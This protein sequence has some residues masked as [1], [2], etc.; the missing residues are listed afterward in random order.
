MDRHPVPRFKLNT[1][2]RLCELNQIQMN[3]FVATTWANET[4]V[5]E[6]ISFTDDINQAGA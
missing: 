3:N 2:A 5:P 4:G 1:P 6:E